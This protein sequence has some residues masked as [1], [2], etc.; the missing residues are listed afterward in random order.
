MSHILVEHN[1]IKHSTVLEFGSWKLF[2]FRVS[3]Y[4]D[5]DC[6]V[7]FYSDTLDSIYC[8]FGDEGAPL[9]NEFSSDARAYDLINQVLV[10]RGVDRCG[11]FL[12]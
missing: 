1:P 10:L 4:I 2:H 6:V 5:L 8:E 11:Y 9:R 12:G 3:L 7:L